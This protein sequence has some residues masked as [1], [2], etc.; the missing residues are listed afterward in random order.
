MQ[1]SL[2]LRMH[3]SLLLCT[4]MAFC[5]A[6]LVLTLQLHVL[7]QAASGSERAQHCGLVPCERKTQKMQKGGGEQ[8]TFY[9]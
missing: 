7:L 4:F 9:P 5:D 8:P 1:F 2:P 3:A 6:V